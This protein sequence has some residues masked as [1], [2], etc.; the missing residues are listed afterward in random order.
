MLSDE[1]Y[2]L[3]KSCFQSVWLRSLSLVMFKTRQIYSFD[4]VSRSF[5]VGF[6]FGKELNT[7]SVGFKP[8]FK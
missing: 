4:N 7:I 3:R 6:A 2:V 1:S 8:A 5:D